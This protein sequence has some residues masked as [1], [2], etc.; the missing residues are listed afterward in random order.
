MN[1]L[2]W[3]LLL[4]AFL[5]FSF[6]QFWSCRPEQVEQQKVKNLIIMIGD[7]MGFQQLGLLNAYVKYAPH[8][9]Y[10]AR[11]R[12]SALEQVIAAGELGFVYHEAANALVTDS[13]A[14]SSQ[15]ASG[16]WTGVEMLG[17]DVSGNPVITILEKAKQHGKATGLVSD[18]RI[19]HATPAGFIVH[20]A[21][22][23]D[24][25]N[26]A[27]K[28][29]AS[30]IDVLLSG[31]L[32]HWIPQSVNEPDSHQARLIKTMI[33]DSFP[34]ESKRKD[35]RNLLREAKN[36]GYTLVF[37]RQQLQRTNTDQ[38][39]GLFS[40]S[41]MP[42][43]IQE[44]A[45]KHDPDRNF[46]TLKELALKAMEILSRNEEGFFLM[47]E[48]GQIDF[49]CHN[50]DAGRLLHEMI[51]F[52][53]TIAA[54]YNWVQ[55]R[56]DTMLII[57]ADHETGGVSFSYARHNIPQPKD[58]P[59]KLF[60]HTQFK[61]NYNYGHHQL[62]DKLYHQKASYNAIFDIFDSLPSE[63]QTPDRLAEI[64]NAHLEFKIT[65]HDAMTILTREINE[66]YQPEH[67]YLKIRTFPKIND[68]R[69]FYV[70]GNRIRANILARIVAKDQMTVW[71]TGTHTNTPVPLIVLG[72][73][74]SSDGFSKLLHSTEWAQQAMNVFVPE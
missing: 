38:L 11:K 6:T 62:L 73:Q 51:R 50:N 5:V 64:V 1:K 26:I 60:S 31:G 44:S 74:Q 2:I 20:Q 55:Q 28:L 46:P 47:I 30:G 24:E 65:P 17:A 67:K 21:N 33:S 56:D 25:N 13:A 61:P 19:T 18:T 32:R 68:F 14:A 3:L 40:N 16:Q 41:I 37:N 70:Y 8:S 66:Y 10:I 7:G 58:L 36:K 9:I 71:S 48:S 35:E 27:L 23:Y 69:E 39:L 57:T 43:A 15:M 34:L 45:L 42:D 54:V 72:S 53:E 12:T 29:G 49:A 4:L 22:R 59:G 52:D 63:Q